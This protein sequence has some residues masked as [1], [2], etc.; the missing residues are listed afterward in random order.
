MTNFQGILDTIYETAKA[1]KN[2]GEVANYIP[3]LAK[4]KEDHFGMY[5]NKLQGEDYFVGEWDIPFSIQRNIKRKK[6]KK[7]EYNSEN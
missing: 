6:V 2:K 3:E 7:K 5:L 1:T 4:I